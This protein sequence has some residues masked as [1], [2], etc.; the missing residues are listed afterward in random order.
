M[1]QHQDIQKEKAN[2]ISMIEQLKEIK[3]ALQF[4]AGYFTY[5]VKKDCECADSFI[6][7][8]EGLIASQALTLIDQLI[9]A[10][11][12]ADDEVNQ[13]LERAK[14]AVP[15]AQLLDRGQWA[16]SSPLKQSLNILARLMEILPAAMN[17][18]V[19]SKGE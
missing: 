19:I 9:N 11:T 4:Y 1:N 6:L 10:Q 13:L 5:P 12:P 15:M 17:K 14:L 3:K 2:G 7:K 18:P 8:D 16:D